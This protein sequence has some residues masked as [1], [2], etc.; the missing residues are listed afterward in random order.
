MKMPYN[1]KKTKIKQA[2]KAEQ[3]VQTQEILEKIFLT[4][5]YK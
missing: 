5:K 3:E 2:I 4:H 1:L